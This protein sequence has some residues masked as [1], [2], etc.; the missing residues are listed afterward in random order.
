LAGL[1]IVSL[2][3]LT[4]QFNIQ[5]YLRYM[6]PAMLLLLPAYAAG[7]SLLGVRVGVVL[8]ILLV[9]AN[10]AYSPN[11]S[12]IHRSGAIYEV[13]VAGGRRDQVRDRIAP[14]L[15]LMEVAQAQQDNVSVVLLTHTRPFAAAAAGDAFVVGW[16]DTEL[17]EA[18]GTGTAERIGELLR[19]F[20]FTHA[21]VQSGETGGAAREAL[22]MRGAR[23]LSQLN[24][25]ALWELPTPLPG[26]IDLKSKRHRPRPT[27][28]Q[29]SKTYSE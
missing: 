24:G 7:A 2:I 13:F 6:Y 29:S 23:P 15:R 1:F 9:A 21:I 5:S 8:S 3:L 18:Y 4:I 28:P 25:M 14:E 11:A 20:A 12:W 26:A 22:K 17:S 16:Y 19:S 27:I 10:L